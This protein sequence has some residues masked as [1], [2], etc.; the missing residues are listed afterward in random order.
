MQLITNGDLR[1]VFKI[2]YDSICFAMQN[3]SRLESREEYGHKRYV[4]GHENTLKLFCDKKEANYRIINLH[5]R[6]SRSGNSLWYNILEA[7]KIFGIVDDVHFY[8]SLET[9][10][11]NKIAVDRAMNDLVDKPNRLIEPVKII[12]PKII[13]SKGYGNDEYRITD[14]GDYYLYLVT[15][16]E[17]KERYGEPGRS[18]IKE[19]KS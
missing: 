3:R 2:A 5:Q 11:H 16:P 6:K 15:W 1:E 18:L 8:P 17:Y 12:N 14:K 4:I 7:V 19:Y 9:L 10:G 13:K